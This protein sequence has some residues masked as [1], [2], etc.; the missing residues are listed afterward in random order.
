M[1]GVKIEIQDTGL[2]SIGGSE[3]YTKAGSGYLNLY[4]TT[5]RPE[6]DVVGTNHES[7]RISSGVRT[8][9]SNEVISSLPTRITIQ[10]LYALD[11]IADFGTILSMSRTLGLKQIKGGLGLLGVMP[12]S[13]SDDTVYVIIK[14]I[15]PSEVISDSTTTIGYTMQLEVVEE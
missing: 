15:K 10:G 4:A 1:V 6:F 12:G 8:A 7:A 13:Q 5:M 11:D 3:V 9:A 2:D 14:S